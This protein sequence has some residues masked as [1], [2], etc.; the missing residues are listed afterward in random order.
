ML[1]KKEEKKKNARRKRERTMFPKKKSNAKLGTKSKEES[2]IRLRHS[3][4][5]GTD[6]D[7]E[8]KERKYSEDDDEYEMDKNKEKEKKY[9]KTEDGEEDV[10]NN[11]SYS[12]EGENSEEED[13]D[14]E[15]EEEFGNWIFS[16][17]CGLKCTSEDPRNRWPNGEQF[18]CHGCSVWSHNSCIYPSFKKEKEF[19]QSNVLFC[20][21]CNREL[22]ELV[23]GT[24][25]N[26]FERMKGAEEAGGSEG[27]YPRGAP[28]LVR[29]GPRGVT[30]ADVRTTL[31]DG[32][33]IRIRYKSTL[34]ECMRGGTE[35]KAIED[36][37]LPKHIERKI[38]QDRAKKIRNGY[39]VDEEVEEKD[40]DEEEEEDEEDH[41]DLE[42]LDKDEFEI[43]RILTT[44]DVL[45]SLSF[46][47][48]KTLSTLSKE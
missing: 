19:F 29:Q 11:G 32:V 30:R 15:S 25:D 18:E 3:L 47:D 42:N 16:C 10:E 44:S 48:S 20:D 22:M 13:S 27:K 36:I 2:R 35:Y 5:K 23:R 12:D 6:N 31:S 46:W 41:A 34:M 28:I 17:V 1:R 4:K 38:K 7:E 39:D 9:N 21:K 8:T 14:E 45:Q 24:S 33:N 26:Y 40:L 37:R 43:Y